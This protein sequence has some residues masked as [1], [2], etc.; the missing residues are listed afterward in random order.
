MSATVSAEESLAPSPSIS[1]GRSE[2]SS[3]TSP[4]T[5]GTST[6]T[7][8]ADDASTPPELGPDDAG[9]TLTL[10]DVRNRNE[11]RDNHGFADDTYKVGS[12][13]TVGIGGTVEGC[14]RDRTV[15]M[16]LR[17]A[18]QFKTLS[19]RLGQD[20]NA[21]ETGSTN[22]TLVSQIWGNDNEVLVTK[23]AK[24]TSST[25]VEADIEEVVVA[26]IVLYVD[27]TDCDLGSKVTAV[28]SDLKM[29]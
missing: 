14:G 7:E 28:I 10:Q 12:T 5:S 3:P 21:T 11:L 6:A 25:T 2:A 23:R 17:P 26:Q 8:P 22:L 9:R 20:V 19:F 15:I 27:N 16:D 29:Q 1:V 13:P 4:A 18:Q 24:I